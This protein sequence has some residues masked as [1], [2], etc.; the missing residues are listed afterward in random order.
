MVLPCRKTLPTGK[1]RLSLLEA[2]EVR[3]LGIIYKLASESLLLENLYILL[4]F[5]GYKDDD[6]LLLLIILLSILYIVKEELLLIYNDLSL[7]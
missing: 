3:S 5:K 2:S 7:I 4:T 1:P 6:Y